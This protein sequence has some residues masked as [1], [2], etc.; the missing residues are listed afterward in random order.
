[1]PQTLL[2]ELERFATS[3]IDAQETLL[4]IMR[5]K[6]TALTT[7]NTAALAALEAPETEAA[8]RLQVLVTW[9]AKLL[10]AARHIGRNFDS[11]TDL[12]HSLVAPQSSAVV[13]LLE[14]ARRLAVAVQQESWVQW[15]ITNRCCNFYGEVLELI[16]HGGR[17]SPT[18]HQADWSRHGGALLDASA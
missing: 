18:Y 4:E 9:R 11:L 16:A 12:A 10:Q 15:V 3:L 8:Q 5:R 1:M 2:T 13:T 7:S 6:R 17:K 14:Q